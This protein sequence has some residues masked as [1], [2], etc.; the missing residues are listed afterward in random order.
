M[1]VN[2]S[3]V[4]ARYGLT[5]GT[6]IP[7]WRGSDPIAMAE[8]VVHTSKRMLRKDRAHIRLM[9]IRDG[10]GQWNIVR[11]DARNRAE[12]HLLMRMAATYVESVGAD[13]IVD[14]GEVWMLAADRQVDIV[15]VDALGETPGVQEGLRVFV[16]TREGFRREYLTPFKKG[17]F[18]GIKLGDTEL[19]ERLP[20]PFYFA[21]VL[22]VWRKQ[23]SLKTET[24]ETR[25]RLWEPDPLDICFCGGPKRFVECC[26]S[27]ID[28]GEA[29]HTGE[30]EINTLL[31]K[32]QYA[33]AEML[34]RAAL[35]QYVIW[36]KQHTAIMQNRDKKLYAE[37]IQIDV[38]ALDAHIDLLSRAA[39]ANG[40]ED[41]TISQLQQIG[42]IIQIPE[43]ALRVSARVVEMILRKT[44]SDAAAEQL[45]SLGDPE[46]L[47]DTLGLMLAADLI[48]L[49][50]QKQRELLRRAVECA[51]R[52]GERW[53]AQL[54]LI[55]N[56][57]GCVDRPR[58]TDV[59]RKAV[60]KLIEEIREVGDAQ[61]ELADACYSQWQIT[62]D[63][64]DFSLARDQ[65]EKFTDTKG[66]LR[67]A[68]I[69]IDH[70][71]FEEAEDVL[72]DPLSQHEL[73]AQMLIVDA[74]VRAG[75]PE[76][77][78]SLF[79]QIDSE[80]VRGS[81]LEYLYAVTCSILALQRD[82]PELKALALSTLSDL[83]SM[84]PHDSKHVEVL[85]DALNKNTSD[86]ASLIARVRSLI[87]L[88]R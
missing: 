37:L 23:G 84:A 36:V 30:K 17:V 57:M 71:N 59:A 60:A 39:T 1:N 2:P 18:G 46:G 75:K 40:Q 25:P 41:S 26:Q 76:D 63:E 24:G 48:D 80:R 15:D 43:L 49:P 10:D 29:A 70:R 58:D 61:E 32:Q 34:A 33:R 51:T 11:L 81:G 5:E 9:F 4:N 28:S 19:H 85:R 77:A 69:L 35:A 67:L 22:E 52:D 88:T 31:E 42:A 65:A 62:G 12:K 6:R 72:H 83:P 79:R 87:S 53:L 82:D 13:A 50:F 68:C 56:L 55:H 54:K 45:R 21:P 16:A 20:L 38:P 73:R 27:L 86:R 74:R 7:R 47:H 3:E 14:V 78:L 44:G 8:M 66:R 64:R